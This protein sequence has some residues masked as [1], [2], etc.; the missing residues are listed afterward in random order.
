[1]KV[2]GLDS[3]SKESGEIFYMQKYKAICAIEIQTKHFNFPLQFSIE[4]GPLGN[5]IIN[6]ED[7]SQQ[8]D[9]PVLPVTKQLKE[10][11]TNMYK[12]GNLP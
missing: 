1:M 12:E 5:K 3:I 9:Y 8:I 6:I 11:I 4:T 7:F 2:L 10:M